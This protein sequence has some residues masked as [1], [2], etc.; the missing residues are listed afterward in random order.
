MSISN[1]IRLTRLE[2]HGVLKAEGTLV[3]WDPSMTT[4]FFFSH[5]WTSFSHPDP[6]SDQLRALQRVF[7]RM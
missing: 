2:P 4:V 3:E 5:Q 1:F 7:L 6:T